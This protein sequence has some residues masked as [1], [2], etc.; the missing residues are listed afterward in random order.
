MVVEPEPEPE[1]EPAL[2][3]VSESDDLDSAEE[4]YI[5][6]FL[7]EAKEEVSG[8]EPVSQP[9]YEPQRR[10]HFQEPVKPAARYPNP[11][12]QYHQP[13][14]VSRLNDPYRRNHAMRQPPRA[15]VKAR[16]RQKMRYSTHYGVGGGV[17]G[18]Q[19]KASMLYSHCFG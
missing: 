7:N 13:A 12:Q 16:G 10:V 18:T 3:E 15:P 6:D 4:Q 8:P 9:R 14:P 5:D 2:T 17:L 1:P 11:V 19:A